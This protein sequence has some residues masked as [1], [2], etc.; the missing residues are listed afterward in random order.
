M[1]SVFASLQPIS[2]QYLNVGVSEQNMIN[3]AAGLALA[4]KTVLLQHSVFRY[5]KM[6]RANK[7]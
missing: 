4:G 3:V 6:F 1:L 7:S 5:F 2:D